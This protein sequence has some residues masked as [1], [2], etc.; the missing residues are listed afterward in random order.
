MRQSTGA[1]MVDCCVLRVPRRSCGV[2][3]PPPRRPPSPPPAPAPSPHS[4][5]SPPFA[6]VLRPV[7]IDGDDTTRR[8]TPPPVPPR[9][10]RWRR[11][12]PRAPEERRPHRLELP[13]HLVRPRRPGPSAHHSSPAP[14][15]TSEPYSSPKPLQ[16]EMRRPFNQRMLT[17]RYV[18]VGGGNKRAGISAAIVRAVWCV[19]E[20]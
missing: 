14:Q 19:R 13:L 16:F 9:R 6:P 15:L 11:G 5:P 17:R 10:R 18:L 1:M 4:P 7:D 3:P 8:R 20:E 12:Q 2:A